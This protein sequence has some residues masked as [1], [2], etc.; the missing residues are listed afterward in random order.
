MELGLKGI[1]YV[2]DN[3]AR[4][5]LEKLFSLY[6]S[7]LIKTHDVVFLGGESEVYEVVYRL[8]LAT[9]A[10]RIVGVLDADQKNEYK[11]N[12]F[13]GKFFFLPGSLPPEKELLAAVYNHRGEFARALLTREAVVV[14]AI[15]RCEG[16]NHH[17][18]FEEFSRVLYGEVRS[19]V[20]ELA[21]GVWFAYYTNRE[22]IHSLMRLLDPALSEENIAEVDRVFPPQ[23]PAAA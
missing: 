3:K 5:F 13:P 7:E 21:F 9:P 19:S 8:P 10:F 16:L 12:D 23:L 20:Y 4:V 1:L 14:D 17:D 15:R 2:E 18:F 22:E 11:Y 6:G